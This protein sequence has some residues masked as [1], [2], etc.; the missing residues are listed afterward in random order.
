MAHPALPLQQAILN[1]L[2]DDPA[3]TALVGTRVFDHVPA[4]AAF[5]YIAIGDDAFARDLWRHEAFVTVLVFTQKI[6][7]PAVKRLSALVQS[8]LD[9]D[10]VLNDWRTLEWSFEK[11]NFSED[12]KQGVQMA[13]I[14]FRYLFEEDDYWQ[15]EDGDEIT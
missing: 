1:A 3:I 9:R 10:L 6:G 13:E 14:E 2:L 12:K 7:L 5:P 8:C 11:M 4:D 15:Q